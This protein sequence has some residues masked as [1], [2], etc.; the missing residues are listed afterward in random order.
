ME[1][2]ALR[3]EPEDLDLGPNPAIYQL[4]GLRQG[5]QLSPRFVTC[6]A[7]MF[8]SMITLLLLTSEGCSEAQ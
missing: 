8:S 2:K 1:E 6:L 4:Q 3:L 7:P 5:T